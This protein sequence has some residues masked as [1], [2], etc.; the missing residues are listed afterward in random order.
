MIRQNTFTVCAL[1][2]LQKFAFAVQHFLYYRP[3][4]LLIIIFH[5]SSSSVVIIATN[6]GLWDG[7]FN[8]EIICQPVQRARRIFLHPICPPWCM[9][10]DALWKCVISLLE[11]TSQLTI[12]NNCLQMSAFAKQKCN[13][14]KSELMNVLCY[15]SI[16]KCNKSMMNLGCFGTTFQ[17]MTF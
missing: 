3:Y 12:S 4:T 8:V 17:I 9:S 16:A 14:K 13:F 1:K 10:T 2:H 5:P 11:I 15:L 6:G 7:F